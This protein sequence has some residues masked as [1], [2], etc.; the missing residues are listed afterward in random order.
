MENQTTYVKLLQSTLKQMH[1]EVLCYTCFITDYLCSAEAHTDAV[2]TLDIK[3]LLEK[4]NPCNT[5]IKHT[6]T[7]PFN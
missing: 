7:K 2:A 6:F 1:I 5:T 4:H 3:I